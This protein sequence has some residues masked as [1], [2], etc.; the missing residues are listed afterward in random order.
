MTILSWLMLPA[1]ALA[2]QAATPPEAGETLQIVAFGDS[3]SAGYGV[4]PGESFPEQLQAALRDAGHD[5]SV[6]NAGVSGDTTSGGLARLEWSVPQE[7]DLVIVELGAN[8]ALRGIS[9]EITERN[10]DQILAKL[11]AR[12]QAALLAGMMAPPNMGADYAAEFD[13]IYQRLADK[14]DVAFYPFFLDGVAAEPALN[15]D[16]GM[17]PNPEGVAVIVERILPAVTEA[18]DAISVERETG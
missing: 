5:V 13:G 11:Q 18:L 8:D 9:P 4:G 16:D 12:D 10:L 14:Y 7:A 3:L 15:Q 2:Q 17:H 1:A 6:A